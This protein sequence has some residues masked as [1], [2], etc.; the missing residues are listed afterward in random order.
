MP[1]KPAVSVALLLAVVLC[2]PW[3]VGWLDPPNYPDRRECPHDWDFKRKQEGSGPAS[4]PTARIPEFNDCQR[5]IV[6]RRDSL[7]YDSLFAIFASPSLS[8]LPNLKDYERLGAAEIYAEGTYAPLGITTT[9]SCL[10]LGRD[11]WQAILVPEDEDNPRCLGVVDSSTVHG[12][13]L[14]VRRNTF[15]DFP[16]DSD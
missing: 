9:F 2:S 14:Q 11:P 10:Y 15:R 4:D 7:V 13:I 16:A 12:T 1:R 5:F 8:L 6:V 3:L